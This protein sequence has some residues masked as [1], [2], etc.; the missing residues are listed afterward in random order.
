M[1]I[2]CAL[3]TFTLCVHNSVRGDVNWMRIQRWIGTESE[4][5]SLFIHQITI[6]SHTVMPPWTVALSKLS[7]LGRHTCCIHRPRYWI[8]WSIMLGCSWLDAA[9][10]KTAYQVISCSSSKFTFHVVYYQRP[11][12]NKARQ[13]IG[14]TLVCVW[15][16]LE[17]WLGKSRVETVIWTA[18]GVACQQ[19]FSY[20]LFI[21]FGGVNAINVDSIRIWCAL[22]ECEFNL[23]SNRIQCEKAFRLS[24]RNCHTVPILQLA[25][26]RFC[27]N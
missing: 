14:R 4:L 13:I 26:V 8:Q 21:N 10:N 2:E 16:H 20:N 7:R 25:M 11:C 23:H 17:C 18:V 5:N 1:R 15:I 6:K 22:G 27:R 12:S 19:Q 24:L 9:E 3:V